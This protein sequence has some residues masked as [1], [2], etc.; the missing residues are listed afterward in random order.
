MLMPVHACLE[1]G[2]PQ[3]L[4]SKPTLPRVHKVTSHY[5]YGVCESEVVRGAARTR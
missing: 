3:A 2:E 4:N 1:V 5:D